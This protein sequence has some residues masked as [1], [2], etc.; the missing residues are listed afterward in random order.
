MTHSFS[1][2]IASI[3]AAG[4]CLLHTGMAGAQTPEQAKM[5]EAQRA[6]SQADEKAKAERLAAQRAARKADPMGWVRTLNPL[7]AGGWQFR[8][9]AADGSWASFSTEHQIKRSGHL[10]TVWLR[11]EYPEPQRNAGGDVYFS[12]VEKIQYD[13]AKERAR[14]LLII[15]YSENNIAGSETSEATD[16]KEATWVAIV[17]GTQSENVYQWA[18]EVATGKGGR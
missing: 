18:C 2:L 9:V 6:Q 13:C 16:V 8:G 1:R 11:E 5:W 4:A 12:Y 3:L 17:P 7:T 14:A 10:I 15:Y